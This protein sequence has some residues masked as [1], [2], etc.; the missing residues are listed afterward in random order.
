MS[1]VASS[2]FDLP[3]RTEVPLLIAF[4]DLT[5]FAAQSLRVTD[6]VLADTIDAFYQ[7]VATRIEAAGGTVVKFVGDAALIVFAASAVD[8][9]V[10]ALLDLKQEVDD[11]F[12]ALGWACRMIVKAHFGSAIAGPFGGA[13]PS[14]ST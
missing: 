4:A 6:D 10:Q 2:V 14:A 3:V 13:G 11:W 7:R 1:T 8:A 9:G 5:R 12:A